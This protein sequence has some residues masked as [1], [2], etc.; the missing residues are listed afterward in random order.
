MNKHAQSAVN[1]NAAKYCNP[2]HE[3]ESVK[4]TSK[5]EPKLEPFCVC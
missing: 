2:Q 5:K 1:H 4:L 3:Y